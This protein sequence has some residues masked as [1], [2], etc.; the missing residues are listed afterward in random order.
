[1]SDLRERVARAIYEVPTFGVSSAGW[2]PW[3]DAVNEVREHYRH[4]ADA[5]IALVLEEAARCAE[6]NGMRQYTG[7]PLIDEIAAA[8]RELATK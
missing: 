2:E 7:L 1:M 3:A 4:E 5:A 8:I 6:G